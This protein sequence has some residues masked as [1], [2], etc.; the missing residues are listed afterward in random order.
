LVAL[1]QLLPERGHLLLLLVGHQ[2][3]GAHV[4][5]VLAQ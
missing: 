2:L 1:R 4:R 5:S 3:H